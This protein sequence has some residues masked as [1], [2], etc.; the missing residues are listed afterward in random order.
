MFD[1]VP[2]ISLNGASNLHCKSVDE[3]LNE[4]KVN[5]AIDK[6]LKIVNPIEEVPNFFPYDKV[7]IS[8]E[9]SQCSNA[10]LNEFSFKTV[11]QS[12]DENTTLTPK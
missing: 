3:V 6:N 1:R 2:N 12:L 10:Q 4:E 5:E 7:S 8:S 11:Y 9:V